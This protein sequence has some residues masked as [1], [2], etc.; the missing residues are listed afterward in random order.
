M[1]NQWKSIF[2]EKPTDG[3]TI[4]VRVQ[5]FFGIPLLAVWSESDQSFTAVDTLIV[6]PA[7]VVGRWRSAG[8]PVY[9]ARTIAF[10]SAT[11]I[12]DTTIANALNAM[13]E[14]II[15]NSLESDIVALYPMVGGTAVE[16]KYNFMNPVDSDAAYRLIFYGGWTHSSTGALPN[17]TDAY[18][19]TFLVPFTALG[20]NSTHISYY[21]RT[22][23]NDAVNDMGCLDANYLLMLIRYSG[24]FYPLVNDG[25]TIG[26]V[27]NTSSLGYFIATRDSSTQR[28]GWNNGTLVSTATVT[29]VAAPA[30]SV[31]VGARNNSGTPQLYSN[32]ECAGATIGFGLTDTKAS[33]LSTIVANF[34]IALG[35]NV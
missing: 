10:L 11:G 14:E 4:W 30:F 3:A 15:A 13:D 21:S 24:D 33:A 19:D 26:Q 16:H 8:A 6:I 31:Y 5:W 34:Q 25:S 7:Y 20:T 27:T 23:N 32:R 9:T 28:K 2:K 1:A 35:R 22:E 29:S 12:T 18:A 17:G